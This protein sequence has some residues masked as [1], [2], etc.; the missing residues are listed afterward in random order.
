MTEIFEEFTTD[1]KCRESLHDMTTQFNEGTNRKYWSKFPKDR[2]FS[3]S[4]GGPIRLS[5]VV[6]ETNLG[7]IRF[8]K[9]VLKG[10]GLKLGRWG[11]AGLE[12]RVH[13][14]AHSYARKD[15]REAKAARKYTQVKTAQQAQADGTLDYQSCSY[16]H[17]EI[18]IQTAV[19][20]VLNAMLSHIE[21]ADAKRQAVVVATTSPPLLPVKAITKK[22]RKVAVKPGAIAICRSC[23]K[24]GHLRTSSLQCLKNPKN[25]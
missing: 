14:M 18:D 21:L 13:V 19:Q 25:L 2:D 7:M 1:D 10:L 8:H 9:H 4:S 20:R 23:G 6:G 11:H 15:T 24:Q 22:R 12:R 17:S 16:S 5:L 3:G